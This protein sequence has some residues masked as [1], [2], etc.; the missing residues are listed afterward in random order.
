MQTEMAKKQI[1]SSF[2]QI[3]NVEV[4][5]NKIDPITGELTQIRA[6]KVHEILPC[7]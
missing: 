7:I 6:A 4:G 3:K 1:T 2:D 5:S